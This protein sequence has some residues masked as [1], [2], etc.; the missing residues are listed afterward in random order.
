MTLFTDVGNNDAGF[1]VWLS[2]D[3]ATDIGSVPDDPNNRPVAGTFRPETPGV[4]AFDNV[5]ASGTWTLSITDDSAG[6]F[7]TLQQWSLKIT[8]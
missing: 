5:D 2:D 7:G 4:L 6:D 8:Y 1:L 3:A